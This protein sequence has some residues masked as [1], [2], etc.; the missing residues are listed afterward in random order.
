MGNRKVMHNAMRALSRAFSGLVAALLLLALG[1]LGASAQEMTTEAILGAAESTGARIVHVEP[2]DARL[3]DGVSTRVGLGADGRAEIYIPRGEGGMRTP[4][5]TPTTRMS[6][7]EFRALSGEIRTA[8]RE[9]YGIEIERVYIAGSSTGVPFR[10]PQTNELKTFDRLGF[11]TSDYDGALI[12]QR[13]YELVE[14]LRPRAIR[15]RTTGARTSPDPLPE[16]RERF[17]DISRRYG[18]HVAGMIYRSEAEFQKRMALLNFEV[19]RNVMPEPGPNDRYVA[20]TRAEAIGAAVEAEALRR[21]VETTGAESARETLRR[22]SIGEAEALETLRR[23]RGEAITTVERR[24]PTMNE[25]DRATLANERTRL[26]EVRN[27]STPRPGVTGP[28]RPSLIAEGDVRGVFEAVRESALARAAER[29]ATLPEA[30]RAA[31]RGHLAR[32]RHTGVEIVPSNDL[33]IDYTGETNRVRVTTG[34]LNQLGAGHGVTPEAL[35]ARNRALGLLLGHE[36]AHTMGLRAERAADAEAVRIVRG[37]ERL[38]TRNGRP[39][40]LTEAEIRSTVRLFDA[41]GSRLSDALY[42]I[43][44]G[45]VQGSTEARIRG[46]ERALNNV[47]DPL[48]GFRRADGTLNWSR[49]AGSGALRF[50]TGASHFALALFLKELAVVVKTGDRLRIEEF[51]DG[52]MTTDFFATYALFSTGAAGA[53]IAYGRFLERYIKPRFVSGILR[54]NIVLA[55][56]MALPEIYHGTFSG[57]AFAINVASLGLSSLAVK[58]GLQSISWV[59]NLRRA[60]QAGRLARAAAGLRRFARVGGFF[61]TAAETAVV[62]YLGDELSQAVNAWI[63]D[64][65]ARDRIADATATFLD[66]VGND[67]LDEAAFREALDQFGGEHVGYRNFLYQP[68]FQDEQQYMTR[69]QGAAEEARRL[70]ERREQVLER[71]TQ[72]PAIRAA[73]IREHGSLEGYAAH[74]AE[75]DE[76]TLD[77]RVNEILQSYNRQRDAHMAEVYQGDRRES[78]YLA[79]VTPAWVQDGGLTQ[80]SDFFARFVRSSRGDDLREQARDISG[81]R[82][83]AYDDELAVLNLARRATADETRQRILSERISLVEGL[84]DADRRL[85]ARTTE[86]TVET[87]GAGGTLERELGGGR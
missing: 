67:E 22:A 3:R 84:R 30:E 17:E 43:R 11:G 13:L 46:M 29:L 42:R 57:R 55:T 31:A 69:L 14:Q 49:A 19:G 27:F 48:A 40:P 58:S 74:L 35:A 72:L 80:R 51:F 2:G 44:N 45:L 9:V 23:L 4:L 41:T 38:T 83:Q 10:N 73:A 6:I 70:A 53:N 85:G 7:A 39:S 71:A 47:P 64:R 62:L 20:L 60:D 32:L 86:A 26:T 16:L 33:R 36:V 68:L 21:L 63:D 87:P 25:T 28:V 15:G 78:P 81:N 52:L 54:Q 37:S 1:A 66:S 56:G 65:A 59:V 82:L 61:Y 12:S 5:S 18:R 24:S 76:A 34:L 50:G 75:Q 8:V 77:A 79:G